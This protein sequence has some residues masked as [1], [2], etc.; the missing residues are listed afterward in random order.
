LQGE[1]QKKEAEAKFKEIKAADRDVLLGVKLDVKTA[2]L[3]KNEAEERYKVAQS[4]VDM[5]EESLNLVKK[6]YEGGSARSEER[7]VG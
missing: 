4:S 1:P 3:K 6:Q 5:A 2:Y 7:R